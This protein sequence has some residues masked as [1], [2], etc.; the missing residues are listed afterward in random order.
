MVSTCRVQEEKPDGADL[1]G[2]PIKV[3]VIFLVDM[4]N[5][6]DGW[7][8]LIVKDYLK[9]DKNERITHISPNCR[10]EVAVQD[11]TLEKL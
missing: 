6:P 2:M 7:E 11:I 4:D 10:A 5:L 9:I 8:D 1:M 3:T